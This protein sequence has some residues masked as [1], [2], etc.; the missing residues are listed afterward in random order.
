[1]TFIEIILAAVVSAEFVVAFGL[2]RINIRLAK[3]NDANND[4]MIQQEELMDLTKEKYVLANGR[5]EALEKKVKL[6]SDVLA[7][8]ADMK[9]GG[10]VIEVTRID[11]NDIYVHQG[12]Q[13]R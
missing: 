5:A 6:S 2:W 8:L 11:K 9:A 3:E 1:M 12:S 13:Y 10:A 7:V 4:F